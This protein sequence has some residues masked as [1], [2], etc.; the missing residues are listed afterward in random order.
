LDADTSTI[1]S[2]LGVVASFQLNEEGP[3]M[4]PYNDTN[5]STM[6]S[7]M[8]QREYYKSMILIQEIVQ[9]YYFQEICIERNLSCQPQEGWKWHLT[10]ISSKND[11][12]SFLM[13]N[14]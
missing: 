1:Q 7:A 5:L 8:D 9:H 2:L 12:E 14:L 11:R 4:D 6:V 10:N 13:G 3:N